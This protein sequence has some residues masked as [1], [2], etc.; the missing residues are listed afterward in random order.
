MFEMLGLSFDWEEDKAE[1]NAIKHGI[2]FEEAASVF[3]DVMA[4]IIEDP[5]HSQEEHRR[6]IIGLSNKPRVLF[7]SY[8]ERGD[9]IRIISARKA[10]SNEQRQ[11][12]ANPRNR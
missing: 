1:T 5:D 2:G 12:E 7:V 8:T 3:I 11:H 9:H 4:T 10:T 6:I